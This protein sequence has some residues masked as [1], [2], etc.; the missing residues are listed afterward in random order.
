MG[1]LTDVVIEAQQRASKFCRTISVSPL[2]KDLE[3][4]PKKCQN[5]SKK[6]SGKARF[7]SRTFVALHHDPDPRANT[8]VNQF[9]ALNQLAVL[10]IACTITHLTVKGW[11]PFCNGNERCAEQGG[12][13][14]VET[15]CY[16]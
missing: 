13:S 5:M 16:R 9:C 8:L 10:T 7:G 1:V 6:G 11:K 3:C 2:Y 14:V 4:G 12:L 15:L